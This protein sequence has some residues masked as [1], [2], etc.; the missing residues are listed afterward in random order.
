MMCKPHRMCVCVCILIIMMMMIQL[1][2]VRSECVRL[3][4]ELQSAKQNQSQHRDDHDDHDDHDDDEQRRRAQHELEDAKAQL[5]Q[6]SGQYTA[7]HDDDNHNDYDD[8]A[9]YSLFI[10]IMFIISIVAV[11]CARYLSF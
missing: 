6:L 1:S 10:T 3:E 9:D 5:S 4:A 11:A 8:K 7:V 2:T